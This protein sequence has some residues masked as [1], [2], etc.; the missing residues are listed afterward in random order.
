LLPGGAYYELYEKLK[1]VLFE[2]H[3]QVSTQKIDPESTLAILKITDKLRD[4]ILPQLGVKLDDT[5]EHLGG[6]IWKLYD[7]QSLYLLNYKNQEE[8]N[9]IDNRINQLTKD[10]NAWEKKVISPKE[11]FATQEFKKEYLQ[12]DPNGFPTHDINNQPLSKNQSKKLQKMWST[13]EKLHKQYLD[14]LVKNPKFL[15]DLKSE[16]LELEEKKQKLTPA[17]HS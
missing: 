12:F 14:E 1:Q 17:P 13:Q 15:D 10:L 5:E 8:A 3:N 11:L 2:F 16:K 9:T 4:E 7:K 6:S